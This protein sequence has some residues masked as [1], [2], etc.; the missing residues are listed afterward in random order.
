MIRREM[1]AMLLII[2]GG[3]ILINRVWNA[4]FSATDPG[5]WAMQNL[6]WWAAIAF[7][8]VIA[9][10]WRAAG[11]TLI[12]TTLG[13]VL[14]N[15]LGNWIYQRAYSAN[16]EALLQGNSPEFLETHYG[17]IIFLITLVTCVSL[18][19]WSDQQFL[20]RR[21]HDEILE[22]EAQLD[23]LRAAAKRASPQPSSPQPASPQSAA[24]AATASTV[25]ARDSAPAKGMNDEDRVLESRPEKLIG[26]NIEAP[27]DMDED[28]E[29]ELDI[30]VR[31]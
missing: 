19:L 7:A 1:V 6:G 23:A 3:F 21:R 8:L 10:R 17:W 11:S 16:Q 31:T 24:A 12:G 27:A 14:A 2:G 26:L 13:L 28:P 15:A 22:R 25:T 29:P 20:A 4:N 5:A 18:G 30:P 9:Q